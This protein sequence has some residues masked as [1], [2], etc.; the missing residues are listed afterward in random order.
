M[1]VEIVERASKWLII[2]DGEDGHYIDHFCSWKEA[3]LEHITF[4]RIGINEEL[5]RTALSG[6]KDRD[7]AIEFCNILFDE[8]KIIFM[9]ELSGDE[10]LDKKYF[11]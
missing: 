10:F 4:C 8:D 5:Y 2:S 7:K 9:A 6:F 1:D 11:E 3:L